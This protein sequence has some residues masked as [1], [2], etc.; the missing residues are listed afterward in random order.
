MLSGA[1]QGRA[2]PSAGPL[3]PSGQSPAPST[4]STST[5]G[6]HSATHS[7]RAL[8]DQAGL[9]RAPGTPVGRLLASEGIPVRSPRRVRQRSWQQKVQDWPSNF[10]LS[11]ETSISLFSLDPAGYPLAIACNGLH[12][13]IR[14]PGFYSALPSI[15]T[16]FN[17]SNASRYAR[18][19]AA[20]VGDADARLEALQKQ[21]RTGRGGTWTWLAWW[22][23]VALILAS[24]ANA[25]YLA[26][27][28]RKYQMVLRRDPLASP[29]AKASTLEFSPSKRKVGAVQAFTAR[30]K[31]LIGGTPD[32]EPH[33]F[34][35]QELYVWTPDYVKWSLRFFTL[36]PPPIAFM[37]HFLSPSNFFPFIICGGLILAQTFLL[38]QLYTTLISD[39]AALQA[40]VAHEYNAKFV[41]PR[42]FV[43][44]RD[45][46][47]STSEAEFVQPEDYRLYRGGR[48]HE[49]Q[50]EEGEAEQEVVRRGSGRKV[51]KSMLPRE[52]G[53]DSGVDSPAP[54]RKKGS[55][56]A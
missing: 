25:L 54:R 31:Q 20:A 32:D 33:S 18:Q 14:L 46:C 49:L 52:D 29:N 50:Q 2:R 9:G 11:L 35:V 19:A 24:L 27:R 38:V 22:L 23:S 55:L 56:L 4:S 28:R 26:T 37:Y 15:S 45:A 6:R 17:R 40:E 44:K 7:R 30:I 36:Y 43:Q 8:G 42:I 41:Y 51:R 48:Q 34:P 12:F 5:P 10:L 13:L 1:R 3:D 53:G 21:A 16:L 39:R 47:V